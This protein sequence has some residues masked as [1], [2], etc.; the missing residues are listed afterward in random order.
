VF[1][2]ELVLRIYVAA[3]E[4]L[5]RQ[6]LLGALFAASTWMKKKFMPV[7][8]HSFSPTGGAPGPDCPDCA[9]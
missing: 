6:V 5:D 4:L 2:Y 3:R 8:S 9:M 1:R 7:S